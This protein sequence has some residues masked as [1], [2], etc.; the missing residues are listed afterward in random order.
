MPG[1]KSADARWNEGV[2]QMAET[3]AKRGAQ[4]V[5]EQLREI[6][7][8]LRTVMLRGGDMEAVRHAA[9]RLEKIAAALDYTKHRKRQ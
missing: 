9:E 3:S 2:E 4:M 8:D 1:Q 5:H 7:R 6:A